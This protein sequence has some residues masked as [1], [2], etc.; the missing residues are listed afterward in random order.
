MKIHNVVQHSTAWMKL[1]AGIPTAS[2]FHRLVTP[3]WKIR[4]GDGPHTYLC[5]KLAEKWTGMPLMQ[6]QGFGAIEQGTILEEEAL[7]WFELTTN[8]TVQRVGFITSDDGRMGCS[9]DGLLGETGG[10]EIKCPQPQTHV[11]YLLDGVVPDEYL[12]QVHGSMLVTGRAEW[13]FLSYRRNFP[14]LLLTIKRDEQIQKVM[15]A[16]L[17]GFLERF[18][19]EWA[20]LAALGGRGTMFDWGDVDEQNKH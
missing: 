3:K 19:I 10:I 12:A 18:D 16:A 9:P 11:G 1:R 15:R 7:P 20:R 4:E 8:Q 6:T 14:M 13:N 17:N 5:E 2:E